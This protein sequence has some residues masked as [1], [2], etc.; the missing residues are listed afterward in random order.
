MSQY[1]TR[2][3]TDEGKRE[4]IYR[5]NRRTAKRLGLVY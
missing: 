5:R 1:V 2:K 3:A 4:T